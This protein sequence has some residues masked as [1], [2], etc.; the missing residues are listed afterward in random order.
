MSSSAFETLSTALIAQRLAAQQIPR[1]S[2]A[3]ALSTRTNLM[4][5][6]QRKTL[7]ETLPFV[8]VPGMQ[9]REHKIRGVLSSANIKSMEDLCKTEQEA[10][11]SAV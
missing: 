3:T 6:H 2:S 9:H 1:S 7:Y 8:A 11:V 5:L 4:A 10:E